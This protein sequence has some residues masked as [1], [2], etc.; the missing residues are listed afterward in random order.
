MAGL[1]DQYVTHGGLIEPG[2]TGQGF[3]IE[4]AG[5]HSVPY[6]VRQLSGHIAFLMVDPLGNEI[7]PIMH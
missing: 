7:N 3:L 6:F 4:T 5:L 1:A 2:G